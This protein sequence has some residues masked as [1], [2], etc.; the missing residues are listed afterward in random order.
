MATTR[1]PRKTHGAFVGGKEAREHYVWR[2]MLARCTNP[3]TKDFKR[4]GGRGITVCQRWK[5]YEAF[6]ADM[7][8]CPD[9][10]SLDRVDNNGPYSPQNCRWATRSTQQKNKTTTKFYKEGTT[11]LTMS[12]WAER[13]GISVQLAYYRMKKWGT[14]IKGREWQPQNQN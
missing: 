7:G 9:G 6:L 14:F 11:T 8:K 1:K 10:Y 3:R 5:K 4:Y 12:E 13:L 2:M